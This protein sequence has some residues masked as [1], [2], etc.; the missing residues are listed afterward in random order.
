MT[1][2]FRSMELLAQDFPIGGTPGS[3]NHLWIDD[4][5]DEDD[6]DDDG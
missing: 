6:E 3:D 1:T 4:D 2:N 5:D